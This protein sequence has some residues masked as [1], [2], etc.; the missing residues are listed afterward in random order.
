MILNN[1]ETYTGPTTVSA[2]ILQVNGQLNAASAVT[3]AT[4]STLAGSGAIN[5][6]VT[7]S[8]GGILAPG[9]A[10]IGTLTVNNNVTNSGNLAFRVNKSLSPSQSND[11]A[12]VTGVLTNAGAGMVTVTNLGPALVAGDRFVLFSKALANGA[13][14]TITNVPALANGLGMSNSLAIDGSVKVVA[15]STVLVPTNSPH[16]TGFSL[17]STN[18]VINATNGQ[19]GGTY[20]LLASTNVA[21]PLNQ[22]TVVATNVVNTNG[23]SGAFTFIGTNVV[24]GQQQ[25]Y[26]LSSTN[27]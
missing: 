16:I 21:K 4:N 17:V 23:A 18:V 5:G 8:A 1:T 2:G 13:A 19:S 27:N 20:Y 3:V 9:A 26:I 24:G 12:V 7:V 15:V 22:W 14:L 11:T 25:F 10:S 6:S